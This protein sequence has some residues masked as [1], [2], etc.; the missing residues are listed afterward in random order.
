ME[1]VYFVKDLVTGYIK[2]GR[3]LNPHA[4]LKA[5]QTGNPNQLIILATINGGQIKESEIHR[6][7]TNTGFSGEWF[8]PTEELMKYIE[9]STKVTR[10]GRLVLD[11][12]KVDAQ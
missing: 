1:R 9:T 8:H 4:R 12:L 7:F 3:S 6:R 2:I 5:L 11:S 10:K